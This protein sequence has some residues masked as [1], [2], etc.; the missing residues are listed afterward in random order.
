MGPLGR[1]RS[2]AVIP[3]LHSAPRWRATP[4]EFRGDIWRQ[5][6]RVCVQLCGTVSMTLSVALSQTP[7]YDAVSRI[8]GSYVA[9]CD[10]L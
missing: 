8:P 6:T 9:W 3:R 7:A 1:R 4:V 10:C 2:G 5:K